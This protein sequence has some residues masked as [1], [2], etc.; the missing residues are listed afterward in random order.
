M[1][2]ERF[3]VKSREALLDAQNL[4]GKM[5]NPELRPQ[6]MLISLLQQDKG[7]VPSLLRHVGIYMDQFRREAAKLIDQLPKTSGSNKVRMSNQ[8]NQ[9]TDAA[10]GIARQLGD[11]HVASEILFIG[12]GEVNDKPRQL[13][14]DYGL[15]QDR[16]R[17]ALKILRRGQTV[18][19]E[20][21]E[22]QYE[23]LEKVEAEQRALIE[24]LSNNEA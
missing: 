2:Y 24:K 16:L 18:T 21:A 13:L 15:T 11:S 3:T 19:G 4:A 10:D 20:E 22:S 14:R 5:G 23:S 9:V 7:V 17:E 1:K 12:L 8:A 6:H